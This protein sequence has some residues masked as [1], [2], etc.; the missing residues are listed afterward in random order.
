MCSEQRWKVCTC[1]KNCLSQHT[2]FWYM[3][4]NMLASRRQAV[5]Q[6]YT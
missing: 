5:T 6:V 1:A 4:K 2:C 3:Y